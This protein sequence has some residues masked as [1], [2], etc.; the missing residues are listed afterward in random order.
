MPTRSI[1]LLLL[2]SCSSVAIDPIAIVGGAPSRDARVVAVTIAGGACSGVLVAPSVVVT[3]AHCAVPGVG[4]ANPGVVDDGAVVPSG[5]TSQITQL[6]VARDYTGDVDHDVAALR[7]APPLTMT[8]PLGD[9]AIGDPVQLVGYG[10]AGASQPATR[11]TRRAVTTTISAVAPHHL[12]AGASG[13]TTCVGD[14]GGAAFAGGALVGI[15]SAGNDQC[16]DPVQLVRPDAEPDLAIVIAA[17]TGPCP[18]DGTCD[19]TCATPDPDCDPCAFQGTCTT[20]CPLVDLDCPLGGAPGTSCALATD[21]ESRVCTPAPEGADRGSF[22]SQ[23]CADATDCV[24]PLDQC[25]ADVCTFSGGT[26]GIPGAHCSADADCRSDLCDQG[27]G[28]CTAPCGANDACPAGL[29]CEPVRDGRACTIASGCA[30]T[31]P[32][33]ALAIVMLGWLVGQRFRRRALQSAPRS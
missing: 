11:G 1:A 32:D 10:E 8:A 16:T 27:A 25:T 17:W 12:I 9:A 19:A 6:W 14:S 7:I 18:A 3:A 30:A 5:T 33:P 4:M 28:I 23:A 24:M 15:V 31:H 29:Q 20:T 26:P 13:A 21:C 22:C 2:A